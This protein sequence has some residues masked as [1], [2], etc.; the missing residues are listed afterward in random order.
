MITFTAS[1]TPA[2]LGQLTADTTYGRLSTYQSSAQRWIPSTAEAMTLWT[3]YETAT[4][5]TTG[6]TISSLD[7]AAFGWLLHFRFLTISAPSSNQRLYIRPN[8]SSS[9]YASQYLHI[10]TSGYSCV[11]G[12]TTYSQ[13]GRTEPST[14]GRCVLEGYW[15]I[16]SI[17]GRRM[18]Y[19]ECLAYNGTSAAV[20]QKVGGYWSD[21]TTDITSLY[22]LTAA[23]SMGIGSKFMLYRLAAATTVGT[24]SV[25]T[26]A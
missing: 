12:P 14:S 1:A 6:F 23:S 20:R 10:D 3:Y 18:W 16:S 13:V 9:G 17:D 15:H 19:S 25:P 11:V 26:G 21:S 5:A 2:S 24:V 8:S 7:P 22:I 4:D